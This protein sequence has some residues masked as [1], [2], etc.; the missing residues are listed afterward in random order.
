M[1]DGGIAVLCPAGVC[2]GL[3][4]RPAFQLL[5]KTAIAARLPD[6]MVTYGSLSVDPCGATVNS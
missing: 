6:P 2:E 3:T 1:M 5:S 4:S